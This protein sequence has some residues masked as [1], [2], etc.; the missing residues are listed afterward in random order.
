MITL[1]EARAHVRSRL[2]VPRAQRVRSD[3]ALGLVLRTDVV[4]RRQ[5]PP[6]TNSAMDGFAVRHDDVATAGADLRVA[7]TVAAGTDPTRELAAGEAMRIMTGAPM[8]PGADAVVM[9]EQTEVSGDGRRVR[10]D[11]T[12]EPGRHVRPAGDD[13]EV[14][15]TVLEAGSVVNAAA[16]GV[17]LTIGVDEV[18]VWSRPRVGVLSTGDELVPAGTE[19]GPGQI[20]DSNRPMLLAL[21]AM[22][23]MDVVDLGHVPDDESAIESALRDGAEKCDAVMTSGG[24]SMGD[25]D[26]VKVVLD[27]IAEMR[28]M[29]VRIKPAKPFAFGVIAGDAG[30]V[31]VFGLPGN[32]VSSAVSF[33]LFARPSL[34]AMAGHTLVERPR[35][36]AIA[37]AEIRRRD[38]GKIHFL[39]ARLDGDGDGGWRVTPMAGQGS[40][41][42]GSL[43]RANALVVLEGPDGAAE[44]DEVLA[45]VC[46]RA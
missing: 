2:P 9:V 40:H 42:L 4:S 45:M 23:G 25:F 38:D 13:I 24:V 16:L 29:Q 36:S 26:Y 3:E 14:G 27:R 19:P 1:D 28:W 35:V 20:V 8:P 33:E 43:A 12:V 17:L 46:D 41:H 31:P 5:I 44:G 22:S 18:D 39:R 6:F 21:A 30:A 10:I 11:T 32:P 15:D 37:T 34:L 7:G